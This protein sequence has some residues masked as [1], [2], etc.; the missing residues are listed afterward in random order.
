M[1]EIKRAEPINL[2]ITFNVKKGKGTILQRKKTFS[3]HPLSLATCCY[4]SKRLLKIHPDVYNPEIAYANDFLHIKENRQLLTRLIAVA[5]KNYGKRY[6]KDL[7]AFLIDTL[8]DEEILAAF[9]IVMKQMKIQD[10]INGL[11]LLKA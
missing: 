4:L 9:L 2:E 10:F 5:I 6:S 11:L 3:I 8:S 1:E 7:Q